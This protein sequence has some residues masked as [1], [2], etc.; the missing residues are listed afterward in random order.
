MIRGLMRLP[1]RPRAFT[2]VEILIVLGILGVLCALIFPAFTRAREAGRRTSCANNL[3]QIGLAFQQYVSDSNRFYP[4]DDRYGALLK[5]GWPDRF[6]PTYIKAANIFYCPSH[7]APEYEYRSTPVCSTGDH[8]D[9]G[10]ITEE[11]DYNGSYDIVTYSARVYL[12]HEV[13]VR[14]PASTVLL[15]DGK[16]KSVSTTRNMKG[17]MEDLRRKNDIMPWHQGGNN[18]LFLDGHVKWMPLSVIYEP[19]WWKP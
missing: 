2:L 3:R 16:G 15:L 5:C 13:R 8:M 17:T 9:I 18:H 7:P 1:K 6:F 19:D 14:H 12:L 11:D 10:N 4:P